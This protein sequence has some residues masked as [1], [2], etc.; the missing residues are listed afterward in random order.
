MSL[1]ISRALKTSV[2]GLPVEWKRPPGRP[3]H[4]WL[5]ILGADLQALN[6]GLNSAWRCAQ[7]R[8]HWK[9]CSSSG[10]A[11]DDDDDD[12][13]CM[14]QPDSI[15]D[16]CRTFKVQ[17]WIEK[18]PSSFKISKISYLHSQCADQ[19]TELS[20][21][22]ACASTVTWSSPTSS[23]R[24]CPCQCHHWSTQTEQWLGLLHLSTLAHVRPCTEQTLD[25]DVHGNSAHYPQ[26]RH[27]L[28]SKTV[29]LK[30]LNRL[31]TQTLYVTQIWVQAPWIKILEWTATRI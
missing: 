1:V 11:L 20:G 4:T 9:L 28:G 8:E 5:R 14:S 30:M 17:Q 19:L 24:P 18:H 22:R 25:L 31:W 15:T 2:R 12:S 16:C 23:P 27:R 13:F 29:M 7:D 10:H 26:P 3:R 21:H 6:H